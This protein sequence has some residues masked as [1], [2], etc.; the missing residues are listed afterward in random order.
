MDSDLVH[1]HFG[2]IEQKVEALIET[3]KRVQTEN[4]E[5]KNKLL[6]V[7]ETL[8]EKQE[9]ERQHLQEKEMVRSKI[10]GLLAKLD[11]VAEE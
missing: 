5:L 2:Q 10:D 3:C 1:R 6:S 11:S 8:R 9:A 7:E 4:T